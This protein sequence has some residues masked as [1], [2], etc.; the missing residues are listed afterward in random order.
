MLYGFLGEFVLFEIGSCCVTQDGVQWHVS[1]HY[2]LR[3]LGS[4]DSPASSS[5]VAGITGAHHHAW[6]IF[7]VLVEAGFH[8]FGQAGLKLLTS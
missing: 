6:L 2:N 1:A 8:H 4:C 7:V 3:L 5:Q